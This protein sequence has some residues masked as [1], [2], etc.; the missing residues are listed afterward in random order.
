[1]DC[2]HKLKY[3]FL[4]GTEVGLCEKC[5]CIIDNLHLFDW[6][7]DYF[8]S[9]GY[10]VLKERTARFT[11]YLQ[12][13]ELPSNL[14][15]VL[16]DLFPK[17]NAF[18]SIHSC[19]RKN[20]FRFGSL[21]NAIL[22]KIGEPELAAQFP[23]IVSKTNNKLIVKFVDD[24]F[25]HISHK[26]DKLPANFIPWQKLEMGMIDL[27]GP[28]CKSKVP[29]VVGRPWYFNCGT[30]IGKKYNSATK[31]SKTSDKPTRK[32]KTAERA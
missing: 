20:F 19:N 17:I 7:D 26:V 32:R 15:I 2:E 27:S 14:K 5:E 31:A 10:N 6:R 22:T 13:F 11:S 29:E 1:M 21:L 25:D 24:F 18:F 28:V 16:T 23:T 12:Q 9:I 8:N 3:I 30:N 4:D